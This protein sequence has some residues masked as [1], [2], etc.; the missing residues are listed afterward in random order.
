[1]AGETTNTILET[2]GIAPK[3]YGTQISVASVNKSV[4]MRGGGKAITHVFA[5]GEEF[6]I[7]KLS[8]RST[9]TA[10]AQQQPDSDTAPR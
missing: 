9:T 4:F 5:P 3:Q 6:H 1:M 8:A 7:P 2:A 10:T